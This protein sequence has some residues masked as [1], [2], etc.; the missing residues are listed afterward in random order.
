MPICTN[1][2]VNHDSLGS[3]GLQVEILPDHELESDLDN[4]DSES[5]LE[6]IDENRIICEDFNEYFSDG[7][8][9]IQLPEEPA[10]IDDTHSDLI[11]PLYEDDSDD[12]G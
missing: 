12:A 9:Y 1:V 2:I 7:N 11:N 8:S 3:D 4:T 5:D 6:C 10:L